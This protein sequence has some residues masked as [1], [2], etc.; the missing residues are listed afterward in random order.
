LACELLKRAGSR[1]TA[2]IR[3]HIETQKQALSALDAEITLILGNESKSSRRWRYIRRR[4]AAK[5]IRQ[6]IQDLKG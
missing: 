2:T 4:A 3:A 6:G 5:N 1:A